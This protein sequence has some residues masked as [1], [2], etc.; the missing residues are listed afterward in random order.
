MSTAP[1]THL[2]HVMG[3]PGGEQRLIDFYKRT[4]V[5]R[6]GYSVTARGEKP[7]NEC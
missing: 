4:E 3:V 7:T 1:A 5:P 2:C 6:R